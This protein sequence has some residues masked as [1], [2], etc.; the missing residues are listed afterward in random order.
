MAD[1][2]DAVREGRTTSA[3]NSLLRTQIGTSPP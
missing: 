2:I 1:D 3:E